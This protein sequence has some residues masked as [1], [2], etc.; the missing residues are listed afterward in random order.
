MKLGIFTAFRNEHRSYVESCK[1]LGI[2]YEIIDII[3]DNW[4]D[5][6]LASDCEGF[7]CRT[8]SKFQERKD[9]FNEKLYV[10]N[11]MLNKPIYPS[12]DELYIHE[13]KKMMY[14]F[15][16]LNGLPHVKTNIFYRKQD[17][18]DFLEKAEFPIVFK[19]S[20]GSTS[21]GV[22]IIKTKSR[23]KKIGR[24]VFGILNN[25][26]A[27]GYTPQT[28]GKI[29]PI[30]ARGLLQRH[31]IL[32]QKFVD[33]KWEWRVVK[34]GESYFGHQKLLEGYFASGAAKKGWVKP[35]EELLFLLKRIAD[36]N[37]FYSV[38][39]DVFET[40]TG[41]FVINE[42]QSIIGQATK[43][44]MIIDNNQADLFS[45]LENLFLKKDHLIN[46]AAI[47]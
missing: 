44:L 30:R 29:I 1:E 19:T 26:L 12:Y 33:I 35:P 18:Y 11:K 27:K 15:L 32:L 47:C 36:E 41:K 16:K 25:K 21:K 28:T 8:P 37:N 22:E 3:G 17:Y 40:K 38:S 45:K 14:Y 43:H 39:L 42:I 20:I 13:N 23:A 4:L 31:F 24:K 46:I 10:I 6:I 7:L 2:D 5:E 34:I 9:M